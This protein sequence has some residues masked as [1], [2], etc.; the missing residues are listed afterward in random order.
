[1]KE[2][3]LH[4]ASRA[5]KMLVVLNVIT[6]PAFGAEA[7][8]SPGNKS[9]FVAHEAINDACCQVQLKGTIISGQASNVLMLAA[10]FIAENSFAAP[11]SPTDVDIFPPQVNGISTN[12][13]GLVGF[14]STS[15]H[16]G[17]SGGFC[18]TITGTYWLDLDQAEAAHPGM[19]IGQ[20]L[21]ITL[22]GRWFGVSCSV[23]TTL[24][25]SAELVS[26]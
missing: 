5:A 19:F 3:V 18:P 2:Q 24:T 23:L 8:T 13:D 21:N 25:M 22:L 15:A 1:M 20:P 11:C 17:M 4:S 9:V 26:K 12:P 6:P 14:I 7:T 10:S 16:C